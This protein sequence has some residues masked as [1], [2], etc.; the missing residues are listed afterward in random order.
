MAQDTRLILAV[1]GLLSKCVGSVS[2]LECANNVVSAT[3]FGTTLEV[4]IT[5]AIHHRRTQPHY[6]SE[7]SGVTDQQA[8]ACIVAVCKLAEQRRA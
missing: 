8:Q 7:W 2:A 1:A 3:R 4:A 6:A 5:A